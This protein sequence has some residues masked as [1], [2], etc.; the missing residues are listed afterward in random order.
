MISLKQYQSLSAL[1]NLPVEEVKK[2][3]DFEIEIEEPSASLISNN[4]IKPAFHFNETNTTIKISL[5]D[6]TNSASLVPA[7]NQFISGSNYFK[8]IKKNEL[9]TIQKI[10]QQLEFEKKELDSINQIN[11]R[12]FTQSTGNLLLLNDLSQIKQNIYNIEERLINNNRGLIMLEDPINII[13]HPI[14]YKQS[15]IIKLLIATAK[16]FAV[17]GL[18]FLLLSAAKWIRTT[19]NG[20]KL[21]S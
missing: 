7:L 20:F 12:K 10:N 5:S 15:F 16:G 13:S 2:I 17:A 3:N 8:K 19:Y 9:I 11:I 14:V 4:D 18:V 21:N 6:T 1:L